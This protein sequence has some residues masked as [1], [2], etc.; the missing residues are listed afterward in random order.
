MGWQ[1]GRVV[2]LVSL[3]FFVLGLM[4]FPVGRGVNP[5]RDLSTFNQVVDTGVFLRL[6]LCFFGVSLLFLLISFL[7]PERDV[8]P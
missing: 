4:F 7:I 6:S 1:P 8:P 2:R 3:V 5:K